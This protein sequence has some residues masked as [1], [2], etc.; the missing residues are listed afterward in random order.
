[1]ASD[2][3]LDLSESFNFSIESST[4][5]IE[6]DPGIYGQTTFSSSSRRITFQGRTKMGRH[7]NRN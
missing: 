2:E 7:Q 3:D 4:G 6:S 5:P 1:M